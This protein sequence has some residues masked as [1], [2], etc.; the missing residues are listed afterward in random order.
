[1]GPII[2]IH[3]YDLKSGI[4]LQQFEQALRDAEARGLLRLPGLVAHHFVK[5]VKG[6]RHGAYAALWIYESREA[7]ER[8][9]GQPRA[10][11]RASGLSG[12]LEGVG[13][14]TSGSVFEASPRCDPLHGLRRVE[15]IRTGPTQVLEIKLSVELGSSAEQIWSVAGNLNGLPDWHPSVES[16]V[17]EPAAGG[18]DRSCFSI[19]R[20]GSMRTRSLRALR[21]SSTMWGAF[22]L[23]QVA[24]TDA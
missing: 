2:S 17:L 22:E 24:P 10:V 14:R 9:V 11:S 8:P 1:M 23:Y 4:D 20:R 5:G 12:Y 13:R 15:R 19:P 3:E 16:S 7:W 21:R 6:V 18:V